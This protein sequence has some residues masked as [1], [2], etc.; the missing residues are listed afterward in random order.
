MGGAR[1][2]RGGPSWRKS[3]ARRRIRSAP[4]TASLPLPPTLPTSNLERGP[5]PGLKG[6]A[7]DNP[8]RVTAPAPVGRWKFPDKEVESSP[9]SLHPRPHFPVPGWAGGAG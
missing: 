5:G 1:M 7:V 8:E 3:P 6:A 9:P 2:E 4:P